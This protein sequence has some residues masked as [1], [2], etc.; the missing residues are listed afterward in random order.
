MVERLRWCVLVRLQI[1]VEFV[2]E[3]GSVVVSGV[4]VVADVGETAPSVVTVMCA[5]CAFGL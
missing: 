5:R 3:C 4:L 1:L 2:S